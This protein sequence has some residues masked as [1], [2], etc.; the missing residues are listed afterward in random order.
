MARIRLFI[1]EYCHGCPEFEAEVEKANR[2]DG[3]TDTLIM[4]AHQT[5]CNKIHD[6]IFESVIRKTQEEQ[7][8]QLSLNS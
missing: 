4:C 2:C 5:K 1:H 3:R 7:E 6:H 8:W